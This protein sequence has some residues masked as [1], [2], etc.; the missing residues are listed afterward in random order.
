[1]TAEEANIN[2]AA[3]RLNVSQPAVSRQIKDLEEE[4]GIDLFVRNHNGLTLTEA[5]STALAHAKE[6]LRQVGTMTE[7]MQSFD[8]GRERIS[9]KVGYVSTAL[10]GFL[11]EGMR[12]FN[13]T[14]DNVCVQIYEMSPSAQREALLDGTIDLGLIG[15]PSP[16]VR[17]DFEVAT[18]KKTE[19]AIVLPD[20]HRLAGRKGIDLA[21][22]KEDDFL[23]LHE[24]HFPERPELMA[25]LFGKAGINPRITI[26]ANGL[27]ELL[28]LVGSG[29]GVAMA[30]AD[31][32][33]LPHSGVVFVKMRKPKLTLFF[34]AAWR[35]SEKSAA[36]EALI[37]M[38][39]KVGTV[40]SQGEG[41]SHNPVESPT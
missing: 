18:I 6:V 15:E 13:S 8:A 16:A 37:E 10:P 41:H 9:L 35:K 20:N 27:S 30:P 33:Q 4:F 39:K 21:E 2:R 23:S 7:A 22:L 12:R 17:R 32:A 38:M 5:G 3:A 11:G 34:S 24:K 14:Y 29:A 36:V 28:G 31:L 19:M 26:K 1:M 25:D 40:V